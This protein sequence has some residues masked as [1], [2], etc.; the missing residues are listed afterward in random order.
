MAAATER[1]EDEVNMMDLDLLS[2]EELERYSLLD[3][4]SGLTTRRV[5]ACTRYLSCQ[6]LVSNGAFQFYPEVG[7]FRLF[8]VGPLRSSRV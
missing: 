8:Q 4:Y 7:N 6:L 2:D 5:T 1:D 3:R